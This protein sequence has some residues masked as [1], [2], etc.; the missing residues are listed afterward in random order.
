M[1]SDSPRWHEVSP[2]SFKHEQAGLELL[3]QM[4]PDEAP[5]EVWTNFEFQD[6][7]G[8]I[9]EVD[10]L[11]VGRSRIFL[12]ELKH[13]QGVLTGDQRTWRRF[14][15]SQENPLFLANRKAKRLSGL[16]N[17]WLRSRNLRDAEG[18]LFR[19]PFIK[20]CV[21]LYADNFS[22]Q[23]PQDARKGLY[24]PERSTD[25]NPNDA[26]PPLSERLLEEPDLE[27]P[28]NPLIDKEV[29]NQIFEMIGFARQ[30]KPEV[31]DWRITGQAQSEGSD[32]QEWPV[33]NRFDEHHE[34]RIR[35]YPSK[36]GSNQDEMQRHLNRVRREFRLT[37]DLRHQNIL[38]PSS[39][40]ISDH[41]GPG[42]V[43]DVRPDVQDLRVWMSSHH[44]ELSLRQ[45]ISLVRSLAEALRYAHRHNVVH[46]G[47]RPDV[48]LV[49][50]SQRDVDG[51]PALLVSDWHMAGMTTTADGQLNS[52]ST[53]LSDSLSEGLTAYVAPEGRFVTPGESKLSLDVFALGAVS[54]F[55]V[56]GQEPADNFN[57]LRDRLRESASL[58]AA[59]DLE[60]I[61]AG[62]R[63]LIMDATQSS[64]ALRRGKIPDLAT[65]LKRLDDADLSSAV[66][67]EPG[68]I[69]KLDTARPGDRLTSEFTLERRLGKGA[70]AW[71]LLVKDDT[72]AQCVLK[73]ALTPEHNAR[74]ADEADVLQTVT[75]AR[76]K[77]V[78]HLLREA[79]IN[80]DGHL[81]LVLAFA[82]EN[83]LADE[84]RQRPRLNIDRLER[85]GTDL[86]AGLRELAD[87]GVDHRDI[88]PAN[89]GLKKVDKKER[90]V[91]FDFSLSK[92]DAQVTGAGT[93]PYLDPFLGTPPRTTWDSA[94]D[95][96]AAAVTLYQMATGE[97]IS[98]GDQDSDP[99]VVQGGPNVDSSLFDRSIAGPMGTFF[100]MALARDATHRHGTAAEMLVA[101]SAIFT[102][103]LGTSHDDADS[104]AERA[105]HTTPL[106]RSGL[107]PRAQSALHAIGLATVADLLAQQLFSL[108]N[109]LGTDFATRD[110]VVKRYQEWKQRLGPGNISRKGTPASDELE[111]QARKLVDSLPTRSR[112]SRQALALILGL[113]GRGAE[114]DVFAP[115]SAQFAE[116]GLNS[117]PV[118][119]QRF[120]SLREE[121]RSD[122][123]QGILRK[124][125]FMLYEA[126]ESLG[127]ISSASELADVLSLEL[128]QLTARYL[129]GLISATLNFVDLSN[130][131]PRVESLRPSRRSNVGIPHGLML[132]TKSIAFSIL[133]ILGETCDQLIGESAATNQ[134]IPSTVV[135]SQLREALPVSLSSLQDLRLVTLAASWSQ[136]T[137][138]TP[139]GELYCLSIDA[140]ARIRLTVGAV[141]D[142]YGIS[143][144][145]LVEQVKARFPDADALPSGDRLIQ[146]VRDSGLGLVLADGNMFSTEK[147]AAGTTGLSTNLTRSIVRPRPTASSLQFPHELVRSLQEHS[148][149]ALAAQDR[150]CDHYRDELGR[151]FNARTFDVTER[152]IALIK[153]VAGGR[154]SWDAIVLADAA[155]KSTRPAQGLNEIIRRA[156]PLLSAE[157]T[158]EAR[159]A[160]TENSPLLLVDA[161]PLATYGHMKV[162]AELADVAAAG[163][164]TSV[165]L[166]LPS[167]VGGATPTLDGEPLPLA[168]TAQLVVLDSAVLS[169][170]GA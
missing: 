56:T 169:A 63:A 11:V 100:R 61:P 114:F 45:R 5:F 135:V 139:R 152:L 151:Q 68:G 8:S 132:A 125:N 113:D 2:S 65:Y 76:P 106:S 40:V 54:Y 90:L 99:D 154:P 17:D 77:R 149:L 12:V 115:Q 34:A 10:A 129:R 161:S 14:G 52:G 47:L 136:R 37:R 117:Q 60:G 82:G 111:D 48:I 128:D 41:L 123:A 25:S 110:E 141:A 3:R 35:F 85:W 156:I 150:L 112:A 163:L 7:D 142:N 71:G 16:I 79:P 18:Q 130:G 38:S 88:K 91:L 145:D 87:A 33:V 51:T 46:R 124:T 102:D 50:A 168:H 131:D 32:W 39:L 58:D 67:T 73:V 105:T 9:H 1:R 92:T 159:S 74:L 153:D 13:F 137:G 93:P 118:L 138:A 158:A 160:G 72:G 55:I 95:R 53:I 30:R 23:L 80:I 147:S 84:L 43:M 44:S 143:S 26:L 70:T 108:R 69:V 120:T 83:T 116:F 126:L 22:C 36:P 109:G 27:R 144:V 104:Q 107:T 24:G 94:A 96:Y 86:L 146:A 6:K 29:L 134:L 167:K 64:V 19:S 133:P 140:A 57:E 42:V 21:F 103:E 97:L 166:L 15:N 81:A 31:G 155:D 28:L 89:L 49:D 121:L 165:W 98:Y 119:S 170:K 75:A 122:A 78:V 62:L 20:E 4:L 157:I 164:P 101:W 127:G 148:F 59:V 162:L 66:E